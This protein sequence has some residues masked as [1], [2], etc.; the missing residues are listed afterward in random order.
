MIKTDA[1]FQ[2]NKHVRLLQQVQIRVLSVASERLMN[3]LCHEILEITASLIRF[4]TLLLGKVT[5]LQ[6]LIWE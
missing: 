1:A 6:T 4:I 3:L 5:S 2:K